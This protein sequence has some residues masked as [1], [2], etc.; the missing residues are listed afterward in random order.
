MYNNIK[1]E[2]FTK[3]FVSSTI[4]FIDNMGKCNKKELLFMNNKALTKLEYNKIIDMLVSHANSTLGKNICKQLKP[5]TS[6]DVISN[7]QDETGEAYSLILRKGSIP[8]YSI[9]DITPSLQRLKV[10]GALGMSE[11]LAISY[12][13]DT[14]SN[15]KK[16]AKNIEDI[17]T[18]PLIITEIDM[19]Q[20]L[21]D[22][23][24]TIKKE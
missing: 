17:N 6:I 21:K 20:S 5:T 19:L 7:S 3:L 12:I 15:V 1:P 22:F 9:K 23:N 16:Y 11:L 14:C 2:L 4:F 18:Y 13:L 8:I 24:Q 10:G